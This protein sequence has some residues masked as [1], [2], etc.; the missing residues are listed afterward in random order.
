[1][2]L[3][4]PSLSRVQK[5]CRREVRSQTVQAPISTVPD[6]FFKWSFA[7]A[8][9]HPICPPLLPLFIEAASVIA[10]LIRRYFHDEDGKASRLLLWTLGFFAFLNVYSM[11]AL[12]PQLMQE[13]DA[14]PVQAGATV[15]ATVLA[16]A[17]V[18]P[19]I[20]MLSDAFGRKAILCTSLLALT[21]PTALISVADSLG[22]ILAM[23]FLQGLSIPGIAVVLIAYIAEE[24]GAIGIARMTAAYVGGTVMGGFSGRFV[25]G[26]VGHL[27]GWRGAFVTLAILNL[28]GAL[29]AIWALPGSRCF[30]PKRDFASAFRTLRRHL[31]N[32]RLL[33]ACAVGFC[34]L[35]SLVGT[36][37]YINLHLASPP[38]NLTVAGLANVFCV[39]LVGAVITPIAG[40]FIMRFGLLP[41]L[42]GALAM[43]VA[44]LLL[45]LLPSLGAV[46]LGLIICSSGVFICQSVTISF[47]GACVSDGRSLAT[48]IYYMSYYAGGA[49][50]S[51]LVGI[52]YEQGGWGRS[53]VAIAIVQLI[54]LTA[55]L[56]GWR[57]PATPA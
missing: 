16:V 2:R 22:M 1:M 10:D 52:A 41:S 44:G 15:G 56:I 40:R 31:L 3:Q 45:T 20:G 42:L 46:I 12:L 4:V 30:S 32:Q 50:G 17:L 53:V 34:V 49:F 57:R 11:Q 14:S 7:T 19:F 24:F 39:Y 47:I 21:I 23:R 36:F 55:A 43:S 51:W 18:S 25:T 37:T 33:A 28:L 48:G 27:L 8:C 5:F 38:F 54:A 35:F 6:L 9:I 26:H 13:F 29:L